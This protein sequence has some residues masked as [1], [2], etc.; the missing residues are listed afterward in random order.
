MKH[1]SRYVR[2]IQPAIFCI[3]EYDGQFYVRG[4]RSGVLVVICDTEAEA[5]AHVADLR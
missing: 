4:V 2:A 5:L 3:Q 1:T